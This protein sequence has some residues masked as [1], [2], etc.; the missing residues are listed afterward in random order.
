MCSEPETLT[1]IVASQAEQVVLIGDH[2][3]LQPIVTCKEASELGLSKSMFERLKNYHK[4][5]VGMLTNQYRMNQTICQFPSDHFYGGQLTVDQSVTERE[6]RYPPL[7]YHGNQENTAVFCHVVGEELSGY[8]MEHRGESKTNKE[9]ASRVILI[10]RMLHYKLKIPLSDIMILSPYKA[11]CSLIKD[12]INKA[13][14]DLN[15]VDVGTVVT[16][17]GG[18]R[19]YVILSTVRSL[20]SHSIEEN[21][22][23][24]WLRINLG[25]VADAH[26]I[27]VAIT[28]ARRGLCIVGNKDLLCKDPETWRDLLESYEQRRAVVT[29]NDLC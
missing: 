4:A 16:S 28:R 20:K 9:E 18:E 22:G 14:A 24:H 29:V 27:N 21:P 5:D 26:Q 8:K 11:Q 23:L 17:Q 13:R 19:D 1:P 25:F 10:L 7:F 2:K 6:L 15:K 12:L 3:Q